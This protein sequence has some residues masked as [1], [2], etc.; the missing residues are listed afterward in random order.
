M[1]D[2]CPAHDAPTT[3]NEDL[4][5]R[6]IPQVAQKEHRIELCEPFESGVFRTR[7]FDLITRTVFSGSTV[8]GTQ[9]RLS[10]RKMPPRDCG[11]ENCEVDRSPDDQGS[12]SISARLTRVQHYVNTQHLCFSNALPELRVPREDAVPVAVSRRAV[13]YVEGGIEGQIRG[14]RESNPDCCEVLA[15][16]DVIGGE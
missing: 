5:E 14:D 3:R 12:I 8:V 15:T 9:V 7:G 13:R 6:G 16:R 11:A 10:F 2:I 1:P 4:R